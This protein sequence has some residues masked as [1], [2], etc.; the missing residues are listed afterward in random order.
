MVRDQS[1]ESLPE[2]RQPEIAAGDHR[3][4]TAVGDP[5]LSAPRASGG[6]TAAWPRSQEPGRTGRG[7]RLMLLVDRRR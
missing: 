5:P 1:G 6:D 4:S 2:E 3:T 7:D